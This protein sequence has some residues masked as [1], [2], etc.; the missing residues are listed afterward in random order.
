MQPSPTNQQKAEQHPAPAWLLQALLCA[1]LPPQFGLVSGG[2]PPNPEFLIRVLWW[3]W[4]SK[5]LKKCAG[6]QTQQAFPMRIAS[7]RDRK[8]GPSALLDLT[9]LVANLFSVA[10][11]F[12]ISQICTKR[13]EVKSHG[14]AIVL[15]GP[16]CD[17][18]VKVAIMEAWRED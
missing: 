10:E 13:E 1:L 16:F 6:G 5:D 18:A 12:K 7:K 11:I 15:V 9:Q 14:F 2:D 8:G 3:Q 4:H 17:G